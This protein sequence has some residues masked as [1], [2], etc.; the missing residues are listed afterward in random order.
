MLIILVIS[1]LVDAISGVEGSG[2]IFLLYA[3][4]L[5]AEKVITV[6]HSNHFIEEYVP[7]EK[8]IKA[9]ASL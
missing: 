4:I 1:S 3:I 7:V 5:A 2:V 8:E 9:I 6:Y